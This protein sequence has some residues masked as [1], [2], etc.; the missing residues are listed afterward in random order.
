MARVSVRDILYIEAVDSNVFLYTQSGVYETEKKLYELETLLSARDFIRC[1][2]SLIVNIYHIRAL[3]PEITPLLEDRRRGAGR[4][5]LRCRCAPC[6]QDLAARVREDRDADRGRKRAEASGETGRV[7]TGTVLPVT[8]TAGTVL[9]VT[10]T[11]GT[12]L[13]VTF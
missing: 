5:D 6:Q 3:R 10:V 4:R 9:F 2:K 13:F 12:V 8:V 11:M 7:T 1:G